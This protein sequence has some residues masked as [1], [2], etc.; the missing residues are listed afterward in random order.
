ME[1]DIP[2]VSGQVSAAAA[3]EAKIQVKVVYIGWGEG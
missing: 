3:P 1:K 2:S